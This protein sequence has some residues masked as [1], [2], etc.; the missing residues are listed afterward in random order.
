MRRLGLGEKVTFLGG[1]PD[2]DQVAGVCD[3]YISTSRWEGLPLVLLEVMA[4]DVPIVASDVVGNG[5]VLDGWGVL[6]PPNDAAAAAE[7]Q[8]ALATDPMK[9]QALARRGRAVL[10]ERFLLT[11]MLRDLDHV[12][13]DVW[14][15]EV[16]S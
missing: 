13:R 8:V 11:R 14:G 7:A 2:A 1:R 3:L 4:R 5:D 15:S 16:L 10:H 9:R 12:Y 6:F